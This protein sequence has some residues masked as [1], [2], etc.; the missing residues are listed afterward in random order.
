MII[1]LLL[2]F[3]TFRSS[4]ALAGVFFFLVL[5]FMLLAIGEFMESANAHKAGGILGCITAMIAFYTG[6]A[7]LYSPD[8]SYFV[9]PV[10]DLPKR[11]V[12]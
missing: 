5:T 12:D 2:F 3:A 1:T 6:S 9:L 4:L 11:R 7:G 10:G 8:A